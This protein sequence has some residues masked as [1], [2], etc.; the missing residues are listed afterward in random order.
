MHCSGGVAHDF[1]WLSKAA[2]IT[3][4][5][6][7]RQGHAHQTLHGFPFRAI[8]VYL[9]PEYTL[10][11]LFGPVLFQTLV[12]LGLKLAPIPRLIEIKQRLL[13]GRVH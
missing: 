12:H 9:A 7:P 5:A 6:P 4:S 3:T 2:K 11:P 8:R 10:H 13:G 1:Q